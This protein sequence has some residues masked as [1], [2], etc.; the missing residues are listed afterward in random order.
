M[1]TNRFENAACPLLRLSQSSAAAKEHTVDITLELPNQ[2]RQTARSVFKFMLS[3]QEHENIRWYLED[4]LQYPQ[5]PAPTIASRIEQRMAEIGKELFGHIFNSRDA[6]KLWGRLQ[7]SISDTRIEIATTVRDATVIPWELLRDPDADTPL[8][9]RSKS[10]VRTHSQPAQPTLSP[11]PVMNAVRILLAICRPSASNDVPFRSVAGRIIKG[12]REEARSAFQLDVLRPP[13]FGQL[14]ITLRK[15][16]TDGRPY[17]IVHFDGHGDYSEHDAIPS[18]LLNS[19]RTGTHGYLVFENPEVNGNIEFVGGSTIGCLLEETSVPLLVL[20]AC[21]SAHATDTPAVKQ[22][23]VTNIHDEIRD[24]G[25]LA[26]EVM[27]QGI[28]GIVAMRYNVYVV[29]AAQFVANLYAAIASGLSLGE[30]VALGRKQLAAQPLRASICGPRPLQDWLVPIVYESAPI[31]LFSPSVGKRLTITLRDDNAAPQRGDEMDLPA[32]PDVGFRGRDQTIIALDRAFDSQKIVLLHAYSGSGK[33]ATVAE[34]ARW[35]ALTRGIDGPILFSSFEHYLPLPRLLDL[36]GRMFGPALEESGIQWLTLTD[37][38]RR[39]VTL[40]ILNQVPLL[41]IWDNIEPVSGFPIGSNSSWSAQEQSE[42]LSFLRE[43]RKTKAKFLLT[44]RRDERLWLGD[45]PTRIALPPMPMNEREELAQALALK[46][47]QNLTT[48]EDWHPLLTFTAGNP[49]T[50]AVVVGQA[51]REGLKTKNQIEFFVARLRAGEAAFLD[52]ESEGRSKSLGASLNYG[53]ERAFNETERQQLGLLHLFQGF[54]QAGVLCL[55]GDPKRAY[56]LHAIEGIQLHEA[57]RLLKKAAEIGLLVK[58]GDNKYFIH[59]AA[60]WFFRRLFNHYYR[61]NEAADYADFAFGQVMAALG[62]LYRDE[63]DSGKRE[64]IH[65]LSDEEENLRFVRRMGLEHGWWFQVIG[66]MQSLR[67]VYVELGRWVE[68]ERLVTEILPYFINPTTDQALSEREEYWELVMEYRVQLLRQKRDWKEAERLHKIRLEV[69]RRNAASALK[70]PKENFSANDR[71]EIR[72][73]SVALHYLGE[74]QQETNLADCIETFKEGV[75]LAE[76]CD[77]QSGAAI[78]EFSLSRAFTQKGAFRDLDKAE[79]WCK[80]SLSRWD[81]RDIVAKGKCLSAMAV[82]N[83]ERF[84]DTRRSKT[85]EPHLELLLDSALKFCEAARKQLPTDDYVDLG[86][87]YHH[88]GGILW[89]YGRIKEA[90][91]AYREAIWMHEKT[92]NYLAAGQVRGNIAIILAR[93]G[94][95]IDA[96]DYAIAS[97]RDFEVLSDQG[98]V[99]GEKIR[100]L[101]AKIEQNLARLNQPT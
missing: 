46:F 4:Y 27:D 33:T 67:T 34:F 40:E 17:H 81:S 55:M 96:R 58:R 85:P 23:K 99:E 39:E 61:A 37:A 47:G 50:I 18:P 53:F 52:E 35:Y 80:R 83:L 3:E 92:H 66:A 49:H 9:L 70:K 87:V 25:S 26:Q 63:Y 43:A 2:P 68:W 98:G 42:L 97:L 28:I 74:I 91:D 54:I 93:K 12:I 6:L 29:T 57:N 89:G 32:T 41:W 73:L 14:A 48:F 36:V 51:F 94:E 76:L 60:P 5:D 45:L 77:E 1:D 22:V 21:R 10:F 88:L 95:L 78:C 64:I 15:A 100:R 44:S 72:N 75:R 59:P 86:I 90:M 62:D 7:P 82:I 71:H 56:H 30:A 79:Y 84:E 16:K 19:V 101:L 11:K 31:N 38:K 69:A 8:V 65:T 24:Y 13:T 20:N